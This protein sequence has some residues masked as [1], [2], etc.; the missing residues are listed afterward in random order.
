MNTIK[1]IIKC[2]IIV[3]CYFNV[4]SQEKNTQNIG[5]D[6]YIV[7]KRLKSNKTIERT[8]FSNYDFMYLMTGPKWKET[9]FDQSSSKIQKRLIDSHRYPKGDS[10][11]SLIP[12]LIS[13]AHKH[14]T[15]VLYCI[16]VEFGNPAKSSR[17][18]STYYAVTE[19]LDRRSAFA[20]TIVAYML[21]Y[22]MDGIDIDWEHDVDVHLH[23]DLM[24]AIRKELD[25]VG[26]ADG[27]KYY[28][29]TAMHTS[30]SFTTESVKK[31]TSQV[32]W[33]NFMTYDMGGGK[34]GTVAQHNTPLDLIEEHLESIKE[35]GFPKEQISIGLANYG[36]I[37][38]GID[39]N[40]E[41]QDGLGEK[42]SYIDWNHFKLLLDEG[43]Q[44][45]FDDEAQ[46][47]YYYSPD[48]KD[49]V[50][51]DDKNSLAHKLDWIK[52]NGYE[53]V[54]W[55]EFHHDI[56]IPNDVYE[57]HE[58]QDFVHNKLNDK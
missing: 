11:E 42:G 30:L 24:E 20:Q 41:I 45:V 52:L 13:A 12:G 4:H 3:A 7:G 36:F 31:L 26:K 28:L 9:D 51:I 5:H 27:R 18:K 56:V 29:T 8:N 21:K 46:M 16:G 37:Y 50:S 34:W 47:S 25:I 15:K 6:T 22:N 14:G 23:A 54:F 2:I 10:G 44:G 38:Q 19:D 39:P 35:K 57:V 43:W 33:V 53:R 58:L 49:F 55:W 32:D 40:V 17:S 1:K 48:K